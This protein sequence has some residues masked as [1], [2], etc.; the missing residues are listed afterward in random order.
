M[1]LSFRSAQR[2]LQEWAPAT[3]LL[4]ATDASLEVTSSS[5]EPPR[6]MEAPVVEG[7]TLRAISI[8]GGPDVGFAAFLDGVQRSRVL[9]Y[10]AG[11]PMVFGVAAAVVRV[12]VDRRLRTWRGAPRV[13]RKVYLP[14]SF[15]PPDLPA[16]FE[17]EGVQVVDTTE[18]EDGAQPPVRHPFTLLDLAVHR[19]QEERER[20]EQE[21]AEEWCG[22]ERAPLFIDGGLSRSDGVAG[23]ACAVGVVKSH[24][25]LYVEGDALERVFALQRGERSSVFRL[26]SS[27]R[28]SV[29]SWYLRLRDPAGHS[30]L[31]G[32]VRV[33]VADPEAL[34][35]DTKELTQRADRISRWILAEVSPLALPDGRWDRMVYGIRDCEEFLRASI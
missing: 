33:E 19:V 25:T 17:R 23:S 1:D 9:G 3:P 8:S 27:W 31:W 5:T 22:S 12:R 7:D 15:A 6:L 4:A 21:L 34:G 18:V 24:R 10:H 14:V 13:S 11:L 32:L 26:S 28:A 20:L 29:A 30:P 35:E 2:C 16:Y